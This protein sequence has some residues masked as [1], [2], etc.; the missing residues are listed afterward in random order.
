MM[1]VQDRTPV[2]VGLV[3]PLAVFGGALAVATLP[4]DFP[5]APIV[6]AMAAILGLG[7]VLFVARSRPLP[8]TVGVSADGWSGFVT[9]LER[10]RRYERRMALIRIG[11]GT[12]RGRSGSSLGS[13]IRGVTRQVDQV[14]E[15]RDVV[16]VVVPESGADGVGQLVDRLQATPELRGIETTA[17]IFPEDA[18]TAGA[19]LAAVH[20]GVP[21]PVALPVRMSRE[22]PPPSSRSGDLAQ[23]AKD[24]RA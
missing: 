6:L 4:P 16:Y 3:V 24:L 2:V 5:P 17:A 8:L 22:V 20:T 23:P 13:R 15:D 19:L 1:R 14:W 11:P 10:A 21:D 18:L 9:E 7:T 12:S